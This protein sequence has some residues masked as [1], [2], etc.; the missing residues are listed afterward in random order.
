[1]PTE[2]NFVSIDGFSIAKNR[3]NRNSL[4]KRFSRRTK[5]ARITQT[6][7]LRSQRPLSLA[8]AATTTTGTITNTTINYISQKVNFRILP[9]FTQVPRINLKFR[10]KKRIFS[11]NCLHNPLEMS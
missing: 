11:F 7:R 3:K 2:L 9:S 4:K 5:I 1:M 8:A 10:K 6:V